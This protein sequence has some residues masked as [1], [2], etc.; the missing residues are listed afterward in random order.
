[1]KRN[2]DVQII[3]ID[4]ISLITMHQNNIPHFE[5]VA[6]LS[7]TICALALELEIP[8]TVLSQVARNVEK[9]R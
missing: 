4:H 7:S 3:F 5:Q 2:Y 9:K 1:M 6:F 8:I